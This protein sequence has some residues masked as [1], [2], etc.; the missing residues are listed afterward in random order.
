MAFF[1][2]LQIP[3]QHRAPFQNS[4]AKTPKPTVIRNEPGSPKTI[5]LKDDEAEKFLGDIKY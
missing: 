4:H 3:K 5:V 1:K 2:I